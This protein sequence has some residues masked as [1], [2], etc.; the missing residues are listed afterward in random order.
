MAKSDRHLTVNLSQ[1]MRLASILTR[2]GEILKQFKTYDQEVSKE[3][4]R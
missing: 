3:N 4:H 1:A 2:A